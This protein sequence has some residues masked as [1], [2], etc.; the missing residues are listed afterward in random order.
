MAKSDTI[1]TPRLIIVPFSKKYLT[2]RYVDWLNDP[3]VVKYSEQR[4]ARHTIESCREYMKSF[5]GTPNYFWAIVVR[6]SDCGHI[7]NI[8]AYIDP[9]NHLADMGILI[10]ERSVWGCGFGVEA[11]VAVCGYLIETLKM[12]KI[13]AGTL[14]PNKRMLGLMHAAGMVEDGRRK[15]HYLFEGKETDVLHRALFR[16]TWDTLKKG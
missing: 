10:G 1:K 8:N 5:D 13:T 2:E 9:V 15:R 16:E 6:E 4:H 3:E 7:G 14:A 12:R 11:W